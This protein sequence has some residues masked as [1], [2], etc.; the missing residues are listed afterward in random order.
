[1]VHLRYKLPDVLK[2]A[3]AREKL[4]KLTSNYLFFSSYPQK[5]VIYKDYIYL[6][7]TFQVTENNPIPTKM[8]INSIIGISINWPEYYKMLQKNFELPSKNNIPQ[9]RAK[10]SVAN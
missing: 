3:K 1:M 2:T 5:I 6:G 9:A 4:L 8:I 7:S 10:T